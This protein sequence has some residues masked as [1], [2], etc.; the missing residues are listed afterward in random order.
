MGN[1][2]GFNLHGLQQN[3]EV[4]GFSHR[5]QHDFDAY[6]KC[7]NTSSMGRYKNG[8]LVCNVSKPTVA[9]ECCSCPNVGGNIRGETFQAGCIAGQTNASNGLPYMAGTFVWTLHDYYGEARAGWPSIAASFGSFDLAGFEKGGAW[10]YRSWWRDAVEADD[11]PAVKSHAPRVCRVWNDRWD[12]ELVSKSG[13]INVNAVTASPFAELFVDGKSQGVE[14]L[15][16]PTLP[17]LNNHH[18]GGTAAWAVTV[19]AEDAKLSHSEAGPAHSDSALECTGANSSF[20]IDLKNLKC[21]G[22]R[23]AKGLKSY[24]ASSCAEA[25]CKL[26]GCAVWNL[27]SP[28]GCRMATSGSCWIAPPGLDIS[29]AC[30][31]GDAQAGWVSRGRDGVPT[32]PPTPRKPTPATPP[33]PPTPAPTLPSVRVRAGSNLTLICRSGKASGAQV[34]GVHTVIAPGPAA[35]LRLYID[36]P[37]VSKGTGE[38]LLLDG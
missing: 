32:P 25:C 28:E 15:R 18:K 5:Y 19:L 36:A 37:N 31:P 7:V 4:Q 29:T 17:A 35:A 33:K 9:S 27:C 2:E 23:P 30:T 13:K 11:P 21:I 8:S 12:S 38:A 3:T 10:W 14:A 1:E 24:N 6:H 20:P 16:N 34:T 26:R 22:L